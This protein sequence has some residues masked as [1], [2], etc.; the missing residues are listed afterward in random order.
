MEDNKISKREF[1]LGLLIIGSSF[2]FFIF[3]MCYA[4]YDHYM[5]LDHIRIDELNV[6]FNE[7]ELVNA[8]FL[9][10]DI[11]PEDIELQKEAKGPMVLID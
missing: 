1:I 8:A 5:L 7:T 11:E 4:S 3:G 10:A 2:V 6:D 9:L